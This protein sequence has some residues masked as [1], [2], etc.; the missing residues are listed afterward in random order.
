[1][2]APSVVLVGAQGPGDHVDPSPQAQRSGG[3]AG[4]VGADA[5]PL[6][7]LAAVIYADGDDGFEDE[8]DDND[9]ALPVRRSPRQAAAVRILEGTLFC[10]SDDSTFV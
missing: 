3:A 9:E 4:A 6:E 7:N 5:L 1:M 10:A 2:D 8:C